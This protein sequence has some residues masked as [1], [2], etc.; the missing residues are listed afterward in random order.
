MVRLVLFDI[1]GTL[2][3]T[4]G[5]GVKAFARVFA[6]EFAVIDGFDQLKFAGRTDVNLVRQFFGF[7][8]IPATPRNFERFFERYVFW[9]DHILRESQTALC[10]GVLDFISGLHSLPRPPLLGLLTGNIRL[11]AE[12]KLRHFNLWEVFQTGAFAD[13]HEDRDQIA[14]IARQRGCR[15]LNE[16]LSDDQVLVVGDTPLDIRCG[17]A[18]RAK[19]LAAATG[20]ATLDEL[21]RHRPDWAVTHLREIEPR[22]VVGA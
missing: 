21:K 11:G 12:I 18:I 16:D 2:A 6:T 8:Q 10:P 14:V 9:L 15:V 5:A 7:H 17:R 13:D 1:D 4:G 19:V 3:R 22:M 20:G